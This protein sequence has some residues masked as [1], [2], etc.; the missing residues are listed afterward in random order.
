MSSH[1]QSLKATKP[2]PARQTQSYL[3]SLFAQRGLTPRHRMGQNFLIDLNIHELIVETSGVGPND[4]ILEVGPGAGALTTLMVGRGAG[5]VA[6]ELDPGMAAL[7]EEAVAAYSNVRVLNIDALANKNTLS[8][9]LVENVQAMRTSFPGHVF[10][11][12]ANL[13]YNVATPIITNLLVHPELHPAL[14]VVTIQH[15]LAERM[16]AAPSTSDYGSLSILMQALAEVSIVRVLPPSVF[17][18]RPRVESAVVMIRPIPERR[19]TLDI[20]WFHALVRKTFLHRRKN[21]R[22][23]LAG[24]WSDQWTKAEVD[25]WLATLGFDGQIRAEALH[26]DQFRALADALKKRWGRNSGHDAGEVSEG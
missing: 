25:A 12:V 8:P 19:A 1:S 20:S 3:R 21:L 14:M 26:V 4:L 10:K 5:V 2:M 11:L 22:H 9:V 15:E 13:P 24:M 16:I 6:V 18:P 17:W 7:T 23:V